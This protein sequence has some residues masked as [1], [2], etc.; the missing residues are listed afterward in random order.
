MKLLILND[1]E[2]DELFILE[3]GVYYEDYFELLE[4]IIDKTVELTEYK[5]IYYGDL[6]IKDDDDDE[7]MKIFDTL[8]HHDSANEIEFHKQ[9]N[10]LYNFIN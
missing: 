7:Y 9:F 4:V 5:F 2:C 8:F 1:G 6:L 10:T 3:N